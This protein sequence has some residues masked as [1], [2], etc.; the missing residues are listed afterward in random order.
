MS[1]ALTKDDVRRIGALARLALTPAEED[2]YARQLAEILD[3]A[4]QVSDI[5]TTGVPPTSHVLTRQPADRPD[6]I[7]PPLPRAEALANAPE[8]AV[9]VGLFKVPRVMG[10]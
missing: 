8:P 9:E 10:G 7:Q 4:R 2:L 1:P 6:E 3:Y 5:D